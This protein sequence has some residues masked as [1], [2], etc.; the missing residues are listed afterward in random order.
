MIWGIQ[1]CTGYTFLT[2]LKPASVAQH[3]AYPLGQEGYGFDAQPW[4]LILGLDAL[5]SMLSPNS[6][7][8]KAVKISTYCCY[9]RC[10]TFI[11][12]VGGMPWLQAGATHYHAQLGHSNK[13]RTIKGLVFCYV[14]WLG[15]SIYGIGLW[16][17][18]RCV[19]WSLIVV[20]MAIEF[21]YRNSP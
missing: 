3:V 10:A 18:A 19:V 15:S 8:A 12:K 4:Y 20:R 7:I 2:F 6:I 11:I 5:S 17:S 13:G 9:V 21:K 14:V 1:L 16:T